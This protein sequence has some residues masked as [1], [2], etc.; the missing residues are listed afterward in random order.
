MLVVATERITAPN[1]Y[2]ASQ[3]RLLDLCSEAQIKAFPQA[4]LYNVDDHSAQ[5]KLH[6]LQLVNRHI[7]QGAPIDADT[8]T[9][10]LAVALRNNKRGDVHEELQ[11]MRKHL[12]VRADVAA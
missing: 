5:V 1:N 8:V 3:K 12:L 11:A 6:G 9:K 7:T 2:A 4:F 10:C